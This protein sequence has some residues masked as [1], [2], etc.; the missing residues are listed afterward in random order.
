LFELRTKCTALGDQILSENVIGVALTQ[1]Q[2]SHYD[3]GTGHC[4]VQLTIQT[5]DL[6]AKHQV[7]DRF[8][9]DGHTKALL[10]SQH[11]DGD[12]KTGF[13]SSTGVYGYDAAGEYIDNIMKEE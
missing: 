12:K 3:I 9:K 5:A 6:S 13:V 1:S 4:Y 10:A 2:I 11:M 7:H 8:L